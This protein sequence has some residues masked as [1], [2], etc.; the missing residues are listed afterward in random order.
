MPEPEQV[1]LVFS[2]RAH[3]CKPGYLPGVA[4]DNHLREKGCA[5]QSMDLEFGIALFHAC[6]LHLVFE[7]QVILCD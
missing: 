5:L 3:R 1:E 4:R 7:V 6:N 2:R